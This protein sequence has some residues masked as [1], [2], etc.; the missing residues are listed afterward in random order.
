MHEYELGAPERLRRREDQANEQAEAGRDAAD[1]ARALAAG[2]PEAVRPAAMLHLQR[3]AG[4][5]GIAQL[6]GDEPQAESPVKGVVGR[7]GGESLDAGIRQ[8]MEASF[9]A[10]FSD[11][12]VH[13]GGEAA[14]SARA[15]D[16]HAYTVGNEVVLGEGH[17]PGSPSHERTMAHELTHVLQ[18]RSGPVEGS[19]APGGIRLSS[20]SDR[21]ERAAE[22]TADVVMAG[23]TPGP[24]TTSAAPA[25]QALAAQRGEGTDEAQA[26][27]IQRQATPEEEE[28]ET[29]K[30]ESA[31]A[32]P[33]AKPEELEAKPEE[34][35]KE[36]FQAL[37]IQR[38]EEPT[39][40]PEEAEEEPE[41]QALAIQRE[42]GDEP[43]IGE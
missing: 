29:E 18:Q 34:E 3:A 4:N 36:E 39:D 21:F 17:E 1:A 25:A 42:A 28:K 14:S 15:V 22:T 11:V 40:E 43:E 27:A 8:R 13:S 2:R 7:G 9:G 37:A 10:D 6:L 24:A 12:R 32:K 33:E 26:L 20:P 30:Q 19:E 35:E 41:A 16:A 38:Q 31:E 5:T 23:G